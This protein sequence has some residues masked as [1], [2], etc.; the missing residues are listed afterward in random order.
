MQILCPI[1]EDVPDKPLFIWEDLKILEL[2]QLEEK[3][4]KILQ[5]INQSFDFKIDNH[6]QENYIVLMDGKSLKVSTKWIIIQQNNKNSKTF[7][8]Y[9]DEDIIIMIYDKLYD[10]SKCRIF[11]IVTIK[12]KG[13]IYVYSKSYS[14]LARR[15]FL[16]F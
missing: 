13:K 2:A 10:K 9:F 12:E 6:L 15:Q 1:S 4:H 8:P 3:C 7:N 11:P 5:K 16:N 14:P